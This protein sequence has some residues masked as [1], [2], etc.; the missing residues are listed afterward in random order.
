[1]ETSVF[2]TEEIAEL[3]SVQRIRLQLINKLTNDGVSVPDG[4]A[5]K[6]L[7]GNILDGVDRQVLSRAKLRSDKEDA[8]NNQNDLRVLAEA[9]KTMDTRNYRPVA[10]PEQRRIPL[11]MEHRT[12]V[13]GEMDITNEPLTAQQII[14]D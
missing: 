7:L 12:F 8:R 10:S 13:P 14:R 9:L 3:T 4:S 1:M 11:T 6:V 2:T 5:D